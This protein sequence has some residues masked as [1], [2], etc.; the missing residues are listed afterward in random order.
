MVKVSQS[1]YLERGTGSNKVKGCLKIVQQHRI[2]KK[3]STQYNDHDKFIHLGQMLP[4]QLA[5]SL[6][7]VWF[8]LYKSQ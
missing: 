3:M 7:F 8:S 2:K 1:S 6:L 4:I 5:F